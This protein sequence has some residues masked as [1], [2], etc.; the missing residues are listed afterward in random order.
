[1]ALLHLLAKTAVADIAVRDL[2]HSYLK[3]P[4]SEEDWAIKPSLN[5][6]WKDGGAYALLGPSGCGKTTMLNMISGL[7]APSRGRVLFGERDATNL[8]PERRNIAQVF[9][10][11]VVYGSMTVR[12]NLAFPLKNRGAKPPEIRD[13][14]SDVSEALDLGGVLERRAAGLPADIRQKISLGRGLARDDVG[15]ILFDEPLTVANPGDKWKLRASIKSLRRRV[16]CPMIYVT[17][18]QTEALTFAERIDVMREGRIVQ[19]GSPAELFERPRHL[20]VG[21]F[22]GSPGM[23]ILPCDIDGDCVRLGSVRM[24]VAPFEPSRQG[25]VRLGVRPEFVR[26]CSAGEEGLPARVLSMRDLGRRRVID[27]EAAGESL[28]MSAPENAEIPSEPRITFDPARAY[29]YVDGELAE[30]PGERA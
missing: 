7:A 25:E 4:Q 15:A 8:P 22:I 13:R 29:V 27:L 1:M 12:E 3:E 21:V 11:P 28:K 17:H 24:R 10:F 16:R 5:C 26:F 19:S 14:V 2:A 6:K 18:D 20:F 9:Q 23:N 30:S